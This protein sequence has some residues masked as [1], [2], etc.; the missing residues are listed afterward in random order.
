MDKLLPCPFCG[1]EKPFYTIIPDIGIP[2]GDKGYRAMIKC[3]NR[4]CGCGVTQWALKKQWVTQ[5]IEAVWNR[6]FQSEGE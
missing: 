4:E 1:T 2:S 3:R 6:S 5:S